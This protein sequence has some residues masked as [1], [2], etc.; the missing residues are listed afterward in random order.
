MA[1]GKKV[2]KIRAAAKV[3]FRL[4]ENR[5]GMEEQ[6]V[7]LV[8]LYILCRNSLSNM[9]L[10]LSPRVSRVSTILLTM[11]SRRR[12][13]FPLETPP[14]SELAVPPVLS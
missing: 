3:R 4:I 6:N 9:R 7:Y 14:R 11:L 2:L 5:C 13:M 8:L 10:L 12:V 1:R